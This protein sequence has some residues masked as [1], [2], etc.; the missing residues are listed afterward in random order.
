MLTC[1]RAACTWINFTI[2]DL[3]LAATTS[4]SNAPSEIVSTDS[5]NIAAVVSG[6]IE[7]RRTR[8]IDGRSSTRPLRR[9]AMLDEST[10]KWE[11]SVHMH[12]TE[13]DVYFGEH[14]RRRSP[15][16]CGALNFGASV[17]RLVT[18]YSW[19]DALL[20][21]D[22]HSRAASAPASTPNTIGCSLSDELNAQ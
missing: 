4:M 1:I 6:V 22:V 20:M 13:I 9:H 7:P 15:A 11:L 3:P 10:A 18:E 12:G 5:L 2:S 19:M 17:V 8:V 21:A 16:A 14:G